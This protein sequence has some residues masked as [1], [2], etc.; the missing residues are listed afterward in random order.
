MRN[1]KIMVLNA[2]DLFLFMDK[3]DHQEGPV[4]DLPEVKWQL[5][6]PSLWMNKPKE[7]CQLLAKTILADSPDIL[8]MTEVGGV[9]SLRNFARHLLNDEYEAY[10][11]PSNSDRGIDLGYLVKKTLPFEVRLKTHTRHPLP[12]PAFYFSRDVLRMDLLQEGKP[13]ALFLLVHIKS[14]LDLGKNDFEGRSRRVHEVNGLVDIYLAL[15]KEFPHV[16]IFI[17]GDMNGI[18]GEVETEEEFK[19]IYERTD[20]KDVASMAGIPEEERFSY[21]YFTRGGN[22]FQQQIDYLFLS[23]KFADTIMRE[24]CY[25]PRYRNLEGFP[26]PIPKSYEKKSSLPSDHYP[27]LGTFKLP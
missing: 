4:L 6:S 21:V 16:P 26:L 11:L 22:R 23:E 19:S 3:H 7:K 24:E 9:E 2:Q 17:G 8:M 27:F 18:A 13:Y 20:L 1:F 14:K 25:F 5:M 15:E 12:M 10:S